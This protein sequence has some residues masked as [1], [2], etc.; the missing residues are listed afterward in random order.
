MDSHS[1]KVDWT[2]KGFLALPLLSVALNKSIL[3]YLL[4]LK[5]QYNCISLTFRTDTCCVDQFYMYV[6]NIP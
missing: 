1:C 5:G 4:K 3:K 2:L 6:Q